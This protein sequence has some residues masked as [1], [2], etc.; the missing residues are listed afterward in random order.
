M[1]PGCL[2]LEE[3]P[4]RPLKT[5][6]LGCTESAVTVAITAAF[7]AVALVGGPLPPALVFCD[8]HWICGQGGPPPL[9]GSFVNRKNY[10]SILD[11]WRRFFLSH[12][13]VMQKWFIGNVS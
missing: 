13:F 2:P 9:Q 4:D 12:A 10:K 7:Y 8:P 1:W 5:M 6:N 11:I 3:E